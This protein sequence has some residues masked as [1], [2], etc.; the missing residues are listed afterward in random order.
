MK[1]DRCGGVGMIT[2]HRG[3]P[4]SI[5]YNVRPCSD[6][7]GGVSSCCEVHDEPEPPKESDQ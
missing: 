2:E 6:C 7:I 1:C 5:F 4:D 3:T